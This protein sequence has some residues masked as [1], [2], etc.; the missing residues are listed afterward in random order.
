MFAL[1]CIIGFRKAY[2][3]DKTGQECRDPK[4]IAEHYIKGYF[5]FDLMSGI[6][7]DLMSD[8]IVL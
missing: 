8:N 3:D 4:M 1:D 5:F 2:L 7:F 6:P